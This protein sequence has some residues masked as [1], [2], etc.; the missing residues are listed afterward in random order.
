[1][2]IFLC[3]LLILRQSHLFYLHIELIFNLFNIFTVEV[4]RSYLICRNIRAVSVKYFVVFK[5]LNDSFFWFWAIRSLLAR[6]KIKSLLLHFLRRVVHFKRNW[7]FCFQVLLVFTWR[8]VTVTFTF[9][10]KIYCCF[11]WWSCIWWHPHRSLS[12]GALWISINQILRRK[13]RLRISYW[14]AN[15]LFQLF[16]VFN[17]YRSLTV[18]ALQRGWSNRDWIFNYRFNEFTLQIFKN[19]VFIYISPW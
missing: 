11:N 6:R 4:T 15:L 13:F 3:L 9:N 5:N 17:K 18:F 12:E 16:N 7:L 14:C 2:H 10:F 8:R 19:F 1:M